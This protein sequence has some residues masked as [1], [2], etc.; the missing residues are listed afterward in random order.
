MAIRLSTSFVNT[1][2]PGAYVNSRVRSFSSGIAATGVIAIVGEAERGDHFSDEKLADNSFGPEQMAQIIAKYGSGPI[3]DAANALSAPSNDPDIPGAPNSIV[4]VKTN[5]GVKA[6][7]VVASTYGTLKAANF[8]DYGNSLAYQIEHTQDEQ[9]P[10]VTSDVIDALTDDPSLL[11]GLSFSVRLN[12]GAETVVTLSAVTA[13]HNTIAE[14]AAE[15]NGQ[16]PSGI[17][18]APGTGDTLVFTVAADSLAHQKGWAKSFELIDS[19]PGDLAVLALDA[20][21]LVSGAEPSAE[22]TLTDTQ[23]QDQETFVVSSD[24]VFT[25]GYAGTTATAT[26]NAAGLLTTTV[27]GGSGSNLSVDTKGFATLKNLADYLSAQTGYSAQVS[28]QFA[29]QKPESLDR[30]AAIGI[31]SASARPGRVKRAMQAF[32]KAMETSSLM[33]FEATATAGLPDE[34]TSL[35]FLTGGAKGGTTSASVVDALAKLEGVQVNFIVPLFSRDASEDIVDELTDAASTYTIDAIH[36]ATRSHA[37]KMSTPKLKKNRS[38]ILSFKGDFS[39]AKQKA[40]GLASFRMSLAIQDVQV[41]TSVYQPWY[42]AAVAAGMQA[43]GFYK[44]IFNKLLNVT[45]V[46]DPTGFDGGSPTDVEEALD[47]A[48]LIAENTTAGTL[49][50]SDQTTYG[51]D[52]NFVYNSIQAVYAADLVA[53]DLAAFIGRKFVGQ[54]L[55]DVEEATVASAMSER[56]DLFKRLKLIAGSDDAPLGY[57]NISVE[58]RGPVIYIG[59]EIKLATAVYFLPIELEIS[60]VTSGT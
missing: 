12:G 9:A 48:L 27:V 53:T 3:V 11:D 31:A 35:Q 47:A 41:G 18:C 36:A 24:V 17:S 33:S 43:A 37:L 22:V 1:N 59:V 60:Q 42:L 44:A 54:S 6:S 8:G 23:S 28:P 25:L 34:A 20:G 13:D 55:A 14:L 50:V 52:D 30:F 16:L 19:T 21:L 51:I 39:E 7:K 4:I 2:R 15:I 46:I 45:S 38:A 49:F 58:I 29:S 56:M 5:Q 57:R 26:L 40:G 32:K 10:T